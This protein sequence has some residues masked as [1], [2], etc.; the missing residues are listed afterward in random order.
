MDRRVK[1]EPK[2]D[3][4]RL[5]YALALPLGIASSFTNKPI[6]AAILWSVGYVQTSLCYGT[7]ALIDQLNTFTYRLLLSNGYDY[8]LNNILWV[9]DIS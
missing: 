3:P 5:D 9:N 8:F 2:N 4:T 7:A 6:L 1:I